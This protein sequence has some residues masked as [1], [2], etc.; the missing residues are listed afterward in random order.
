MI[1]CS[2]SLLSSI[3][4][5]DEEEINDDH[6]ILSRNL[7]CEL[8]GNMLSAQPKWHRTLNW[9]SANVPLYLATLTA[10]LPTIKVPYHLLQTLVSSPSSGVNLYC[11]YFKTVHCLKSAY[12]AAV[13]VDKVRIGARKP[14]WN[15]DPEV[16]RT[17]QK[18]K[19]W[20]R[21]WLSCDQPSS[22]AVFF[23]ETKA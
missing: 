15:V 21:M 1:T 22:G 23:C 10:L 18:A 19:F 16:K 6:L 13:P 11:Y 8:S 3:V 5:V 7:S 12:K 2:S 9:D 14:N 20:L 4:R 17:K